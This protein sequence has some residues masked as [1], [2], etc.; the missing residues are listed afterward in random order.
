MLRGRVASVVYR[1]AV[2]AVPADVGFRRKFLEALAPFRFPGAATGLPQCA[3]VQSQGFAAQRS[4]TSKVAS[5]VSVY[6]RT[7]GQV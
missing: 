1:S 4:R 7:H 6:M 2:A 3:R 5:C